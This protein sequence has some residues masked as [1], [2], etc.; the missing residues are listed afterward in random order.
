MSAY[1]VLAYRRQSGA[2]Q[3]PLPARRS[4]PALSSRRAFWVVVRPS[5]VFGGP[6]DDGAVI[7]KLI[8][9]GEAGWCAAETTRRDVAS[10]DDG[11]GRSRS[12]PVD[13]DK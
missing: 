6:S 2:A 4:N 5:V 11:R 8:E 1:T 7:E 3:S 13:A 12:S 9:R 10:S